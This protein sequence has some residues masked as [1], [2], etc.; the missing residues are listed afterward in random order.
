[1]AVAISGS[2]DDPDVVYVDGNDIYTHSGA[3]AEAHQL[4]EWIGEAITP[5]K[6]PTRF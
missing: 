1:V 2:R 4:L 6:S 5:G 3:A